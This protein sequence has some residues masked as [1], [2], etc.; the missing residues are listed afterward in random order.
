MSS[1][2]RFKIM[3]KVC[4]VFS[5]LFLNLS[6]LGRT[7]V[8]R[9]PA[10]ADETSQFQEALKKKTLES[11]KNLC[12]RNYEAPCKFF[13]PQLQMRPV[14]TT[15]PLILSYDLTLEHVPT[16][17]VAPMDRYLVRTQNNKIIKIEVQSLLNP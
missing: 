6:V 15:D 8:F 12:K 10:N 4:L 3:V 17:G 2:R 13:N 14:N 9:R 7:P 5:L 11:I 1:Y 16:E